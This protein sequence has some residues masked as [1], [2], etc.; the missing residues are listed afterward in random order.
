MQFQQYST[1]HPRPRYALTR[2]RR[3]QCAKGHLELERAKGH[4]ELVP[5]LV[6]KGPPSKRKRGAVEK[7][8]RLE[9]DI[10]YYTKQ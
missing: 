2:L 7:R 1:A 3:D 8:E 4:L 5:W 9:V 10:S 6:M